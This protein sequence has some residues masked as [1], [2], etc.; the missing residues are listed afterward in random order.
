MLCPDHETKK[1]SCYH[2]GLEKLVLR[3]FLL[4]GGVQLISHGPCSNI[5]LGPMA[6]LLVS[7]SEIGRKFLWTHVQ[8][9]GRFS[10]GT[11]MRGC[12]VHLENAHK[13]YVCACVCVC[14]VRRLSCM[15]VI[16]RVRMCVCAEWSGE[17]LVTSSLPFPSR[18]MCVCVSSM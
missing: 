15:Y 17:G 10:N 4:S 12:R 9:D 11:H 14:V 8:G 16:E 1:L 18:H 6:Y 7:S 5:R 3:L 2:V 13:M